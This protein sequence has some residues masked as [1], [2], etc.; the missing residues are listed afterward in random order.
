MYTVYRREKIILPTNC[1][2]IL[3]V[4]AVLMAVKAHDDLKKIGENSNL[5]GSL[6]AIK[7]IVLVYLSIVA[8]RWAEW[9][10]LSGDSGMS[11]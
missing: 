4:V 7:S 5:G 1:S 2:L 6:G 11:P 9:I 8:L 10:P 3:L